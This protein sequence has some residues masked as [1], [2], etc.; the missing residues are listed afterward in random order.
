MLRTKY[1]VKDEQGITFIEALATAVLLSVVAVTLYLVVGMPERSLDRAREMAIR[2]QSLW[3]TYGIMERDLA[4]AVSRTP[5]FTYRLI[6]DS[7]LLVFATRLDGVDGPISRVRY[8]WVWESVN[9]ASSTLGHWVRSVEHALKDELPV[10]PDNP[11]RLMQGA[12]IRL[13]YYDLDRSVWRTAWD[14][15]DHLPG[16]VRLE[17]LWTGEGDEDPFSIVLP[18][19]SNQ[20]FARRLAL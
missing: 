15:P 12:R 5:F 17:V 2:S 1:V 14:D 7:I 10:L 19:F 3:A 9:G 4:S 16:A 18:V 20:S 6:G 11:A 13:E 8:E